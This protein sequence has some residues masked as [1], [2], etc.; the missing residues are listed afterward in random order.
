MFVSCTKRPYR[1]SRKK[2]YCMNNLMHFKRLS[3]MQ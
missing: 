3:S 2:P 1:I